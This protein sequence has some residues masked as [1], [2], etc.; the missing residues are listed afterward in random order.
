MRCVGKRRTYVRRRSCLENV[1]RVVTRIVRWYTHAKT[2]PDGVTLSTETLPKPDGVTLS[3]ETLAKPD[4]KTLSKRGEIGKTVL[5]ADRVGVR[6]CVRDWPL[7]RKGVCRKRRLP[8]CGDVSVA[9]QNNNN[10]VA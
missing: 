3:T 4:G 7:C 10:R 1:V 2:K 5:Q 8:S 9:T 6:A